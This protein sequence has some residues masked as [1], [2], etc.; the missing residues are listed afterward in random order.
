MKDPCTFPVFS[1][2]LTALLT[3][4][5]SAQTT[6]DIPVI[7]PSDSLST[8]RYPRE[9]ITLE[10]HPSSHDS[11]EWF[12]R[13]DNQ[14]A[15]HPFPFGWCQ[16]NPKGPSCTLYNKNTSL[17]IEMISKEANGEFLCVASCSRTGRNTSA[18]IILYVE[19]ITFGN[20]HFLH[21][22]HQTEILMIYATLESILF[23]IQYSDHE[24]VYKYKYKYFIGTNTITII[25]KG[26][27]NTIK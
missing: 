11:M 22:E 14:T 25:G 1:T 5:S 9:A 19:G 17:N 18:T 23:C 20:L 7:P 3:V 8:S 10:C 21:E 12:F 27:L 4:R 13:P 24:S 2:F 6:C 15:L 26:P 16:N